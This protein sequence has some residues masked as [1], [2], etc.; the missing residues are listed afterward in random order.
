MRIRSEP[1]VLLQTLDTVAAEFYVTAAEMAHSM[2]HNDISLRRRLQQLTAAGYLLSEIRRAWVPGRPGQ[3]T[4]VTYFC[5][6]Q[7]GKEIVSKCKPLAV[8]PTLLQPFVLPKNKRIANSVFD[9]A[10]SI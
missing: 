5:L 3:L 7:R 4:P 9:Y 10:Q 6:S 1:R 2:G 8:A